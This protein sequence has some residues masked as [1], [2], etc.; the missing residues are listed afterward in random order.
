MIDNLT[1]KGLFLFIL[2]AAIA[3][4]TVEWN[5]IALQGENLQYNLEDFFISKDT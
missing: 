2:S 4:P 3:H 1:I 5:P